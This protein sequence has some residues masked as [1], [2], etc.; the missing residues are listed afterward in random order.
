[1]LHISCVSF[2]THGSRWVVSV[3][4]CLFSWF[5]I[6]TINSVLLTNYPPCLILL[7]APEFRL[8]LELQIF[9]TFQ[10]LKLSQEELSLVGWTLRLFQSPICSLYI[11]IK[12]E[13]VSTIL[14][15]IITDYC[16]KDE[17]IIQI[18]FL[19]TIIIILQMSRFRG[20]FCS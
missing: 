9:G 18:M 1:M 3:A 7:L 6:W 17:Y 5:R 16:Q 13:T 15:K 12:Y 8:V 19:H 11:L 14:I 10:E 20:L 4:C 2:N